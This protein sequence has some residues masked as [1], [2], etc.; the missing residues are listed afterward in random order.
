MLRVRFLLFGILAL[1]RVVAA[2][3]P[4]GS[5]DGVIV[6][7]SGAVIPGVTVV[8]THEPT[9]VTRDVV[10]D[11]QGLF[12][13]P[14]LPVGPYTVKAALPGFQPFETRGVPLTIGQAL[15]VRI[16]LKPGAVTE[17]VTVRGPISASTPAV[18]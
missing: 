15:S 18:E 7:T 13:A 5:I 6:D 10:S 11:A 17:S 8:V 4:T 16:E 1:A 12:R 2:Q 3:T 9:G 14:L